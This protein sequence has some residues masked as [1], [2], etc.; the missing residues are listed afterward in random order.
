MKF[1]GLE[2]LTDETSQLP[3]AISLQ[4]IGYNRLKTLKATANWFERF[5]HIGWLVQ[6]YQRISLVLA[7]SVTAVK[8]PKKAKAS[9]EV[10][11]S[12]VTLSLWTRWPAFTFLGAAGHWTL[13]IES[14]RIG[15]QRFI[16]IQA[17]EPC[18]ALALYGLYSQFPFLPIAGIQEI[19]WRKLD[20]KESLEGLFFVTVVLSPSF[21]FKPIAAAKEEP[22]GLNADEISWLALKERV[23]W[24]QQ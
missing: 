24:G 18:I 4:G 23:W 22:F 7:T 8:L 12:S 15:S 20:E 10:V 13:R 2:G 17:H 6:T 1:E 5:N 16:R 9:I 21:P 11:K 19:G 14:V 3:A